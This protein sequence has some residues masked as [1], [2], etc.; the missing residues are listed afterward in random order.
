MAH[1]S[2]LK[3]GVFGASK[4]LKEKGETEAKERT[5]KRQTEKCASL[6]RV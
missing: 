3:R 1:L 5:V 6:K 4:H 2:R